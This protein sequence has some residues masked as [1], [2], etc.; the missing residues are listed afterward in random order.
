[1]SPPTLAIAEEEEID[2]NSFDSPRRRGVIKSFSEPIGELHQ[3]ALAHKEHPRHRMPSGH[4]EESDNHSSE[5]DDSDHEEDEDSKQYPLQTIA[6]DPSPRPSPSSASVYFMSD[7]EAKSANV[8]D[9]KGKQSPDN[10]SV[11]TNQAKTNTTQGS[12]SSAN[13][14]SNPTNNSPSAN[15]TEATS[16]SASAAHKHRD[17]DEA[18]ISSG[19]D[20]SSVAAVAEPAGEDW[21]TSMDQ[22]QIIGTLGRG[23]YSHVQLVKDLR[24]QRT[25]AFKSLNK[26]HILK[27]QQV[28]HVRGEKK[29]LYMLR[30]SDRYVQIKGF[31][32]SNHLLHFMMDPIMGGEVAG[33]LNKHSWLEEDTVKFLMGDLALTFTHLHSLGIAYRDLKPENILL[34][35][36]GYPVL[37]DFGFAKRIGDERTY[38]KCGTPDYMAPEILELKGHTKL[39]DWWTFG[40]LLFEL[41]VGTPPFFDENPYRIMTNIITGN[42]GEVPEELSPEAVD[43]FNKFLQKDTEVRY[44]GRGMEDIKNHAFFKDLDWDGLIARTLE[45]PEILVPQLSGD[46]DLSLFEDN[47]G[48]D[49]SWQDYEPPEGEPDPFQDF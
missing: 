3:L 21:V 14:P 49:D 2:S 4:E 9:A 6:E 13:G 36:N 27:T 10:L 43:I 26:A 7:A 22:I 25:Y 20:T 1:M 39:A 38:T 32:Q 47:L 12:S 15:S 31:F 29:A 11:S 44:G 24:R 41:M 40:V 23:A 8:L 48:E 46:L 45:A 18:A 28:E 30:G 5:D 42:M 34:N 33:L 37:T 35:N 16:T 19:S 17:D